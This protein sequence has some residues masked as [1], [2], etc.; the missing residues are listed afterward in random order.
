MSLHPAITDLII[1]DVET[2][3][4]LF[5]RGIDGVISSGNLTSSVGLF[6]TNEVA[7]GDEIYIVGQGFS[8]VE[9]VLSETTLTPTGTFTDAINVEFM[10]KGI[11]SQIRM[12]WGLI[13]DE[14][15]KKYIDYTTLVNH[16]DRFVYLH[17]W[18][19]LKVIYRANTDT[20][21]DRMW[22][23]EDVINK[24]LDVAWETIKIDD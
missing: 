10:V 18:M 21:S 4:L 7:N 3:N 12:A 19:T 16:D 22:H 14:L 15:N 23:L 11:A 1:K 2:G 24:E 6:V 8:T 20:S 17:A 5:P 13:L 9:N